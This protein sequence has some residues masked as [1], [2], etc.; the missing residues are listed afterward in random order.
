MLDCHTEDATE[1]LQFADLQLALTVLD[2]RD[3]RG[4]PAEFFPE[5]VES[6]ATIGAKLPDA[7]TNGEGI[8]YV[9]ILRLALSVLGHVIVLSHVVLPN[10]L[11]SAFDLPACAEKNQWWGH[12]VRSGRTD[13][14]TEERGAS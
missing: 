2:D 7:T 6:Q 13:R 5:V 14:C 9:L 3:L 1:L 11:S 4:S 10:G 12:R 8:E